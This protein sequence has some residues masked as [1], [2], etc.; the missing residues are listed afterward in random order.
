MNC[1]NFTKKAPVFLFCRA[2][3]MVPKNGIK[4]EAGTAG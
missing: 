3:K 4:A 2:A 1:E